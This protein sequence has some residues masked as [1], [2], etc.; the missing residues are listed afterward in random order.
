LSEKSKIRIGVIGAGWWSTEYHIPG[1][2]AE[3]EA[4]LVA[5]CEPN[6]ERL[7]AAVKAY[8]LKKTYPDYK[9]M[10][11]NETLDGAIVCTS[12]A[13]HYAIARDCLERGLHVIVE[14]PLTL[15]AKDA[16][17]LVELA[18]QHK[19][20]IMIGYTSHY[21]KQVQRARQAVLGGELGELQYVNS[22]FSTHVKNLLTGVN[23]LGKGPMHYK[24]NAPGENYFNPTQP[25]GS[26]EG[27]LQL[28]HSIGAMF[29]ITN[30]RPVQVQALMNNHGL[31]VDLV[32]A[33]SVAFEG[34]AIGLVGGTGNAGHAYLSSLAVYGTQGAFVSDSMAHFAALCNKDGKQEV[35]DW[36]PSSDQRYTVDHNFI[37]VI[38]GRAENYA[39]GEVGWRAVEL[40]DAAYRSAQLNGQPV[41]IEELYK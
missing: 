31:P 26:G 3:P 19:T 11:D 25:G 23:T 14:K 29:Y 13:T 35:L 21:N 38:Q 2:L 8:S 27:H 24:V 16:R 39:P 33:F 15:L 10:L 34:G 32:D 1:I 7:A 12:H 20:Q 18:A 4:E 22:S 37:E 41:K 28:T 5:V 30:L 17:H 9:T 36:K 40:L 6:P